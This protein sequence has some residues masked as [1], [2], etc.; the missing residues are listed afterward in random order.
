MSHCTIIQKGAGAMESRQGIT[1][2]FEKPVFE[3]LK[4]A[5]KKENRSFNNYI[6]TI[7]KNLSEGVTMTHV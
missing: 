7:I 2:R 6:Q 4:K 3:K 5:A 1:I